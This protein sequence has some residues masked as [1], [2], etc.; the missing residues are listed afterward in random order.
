[1]VYN[2]RM[3]RSDILT[4]TPAACTIASQ[5]LGDTLWPRIPPWYGRLTA[6]ILPPPA[7]DAFGLRYGLAEHVAA[8]RALRWIRRI[9]RLLPERLR[10]VGPYYEAL[11]RLSGRS[12]PDVITQASNKMWI[13]HR[14]L[15]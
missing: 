14:R 3:W 11:G 4:V 8:E 7:R 6:G 5:V 2:E 10:Y 9:H 15:M 13:G 12:R 1:M